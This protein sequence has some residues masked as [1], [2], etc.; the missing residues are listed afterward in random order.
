VVLNQV[1]SVI[2]NTILWGNNGPEIV[3]VDSPVTYVRVL[4][5]IVEGGYPGE[6]VFDVDPQFVAP[7]SGDLYLRE[8]SPAVDA[9]TDT[10]TRTDPGEV[11]VEIPG[12]D[13]RGVS[14]PRGKG[15]DIGAFEYDGPRTFTLTTAV[16]GEGTLDPAPGAHDYEEGT[17]VTLTATPA[18]GYE[19]DH[20]EGAL[21]GP[22]NPAQLTLTADAT[23]T[24]V[25]RMIIPKPPHCAALSSPAGPRAGS[26][27]DLALLCASALALA[28]ARPRAF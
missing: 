11:G 13:I 21:T 17:V 22:A 3:E 23:V 25:F 7:E 26:W 8:G 16:T 5:S 27:A 14:R 18:P 1:Q 15:I 20:W 4:N 10:V 2:A 9:G 19:F 6:T 24:A 28:A 12:D